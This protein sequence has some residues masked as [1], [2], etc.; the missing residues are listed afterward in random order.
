[1]VGRSK[2]R[3]RCAGAMMGV[4]GEGTPFMSSSGGP[5]LA[6]LLHDSFLHADGSV[7]GTTCDTGQ[8]RTTLSGG[9]VFLSNQLL[10]TGAMT[11][12]QL[13]KVPSIISATYGNLAGNYRL[14]FLG[15]STLANCFQIAISSS[16]ITNDKLTAGTPAMVGFTSGDSATQSFTSG[17]V[18]ISGLGTDTYTVTVVDGV[19][20]TKVYVYT[21]ASMPYKTNKYIGLSSDGFTIADDL[22]IQG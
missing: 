2:L 13:T 8:T 19:V 14:Q 6:T 16:G 11:Y 3:R 21:E 20:G 12:T 1:M 7:N 15:D 10:M 4:R 5:A 22:D 18:T 9:P 17:T